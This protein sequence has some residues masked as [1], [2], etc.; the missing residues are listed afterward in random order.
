MFDWWKDEVVKHMVFDRDIRG[1]HGHVHEILGHLDPGNVK[2]YVEK[3]QSKQL[4]RLKARRRRETARHYE[5]KI[6][7]ANKFSRPKGK[8][9]SGPMLT[10]FNGS[11]S[12]LQLIT[13]SES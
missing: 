10:A 12:K 3:A 6:T 13:A 8:A 9:K 5:L 7:K 11:K 2:G 1:P 4:N